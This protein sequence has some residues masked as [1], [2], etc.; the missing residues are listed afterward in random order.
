[1]IKYKHLIGRPYK[2]GEAD[3]YGIIRDFFQDN[4]GITL[5]NYA[6]PADWWNHGLDLY[7]QAAE[8]E[9]FLV[10]EVRPRDLRPGDLLGISIGAA[11]IHHVGVFL[12]ENE[13]K[14]ILHHYTGRLSEVTEFRGVWKNSLCVVGR[15]KDVPPIA[16]D[17]STLNLIDILPERFKN[18]VPPE[19]L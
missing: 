13:P 7:R 6:R 14:P 18:A 17:Q 9:G 11:V 4:W 12:G 1:M 3:C 16:K 2:A 15:H 8:R 5:T 10:G 19:L